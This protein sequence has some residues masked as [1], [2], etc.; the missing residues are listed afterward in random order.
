MTI[1]TKPRTTFSIYVSADGNKH[2]RHIK[3]GCQHGRANLRDDYRLVDG[4][5]KD[6]W[7]FA[8]EHTQSVLKGFNESLVQYALTR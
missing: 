7:F 2:G 6:G 5:S 3:T 8:A 1:P 4:A